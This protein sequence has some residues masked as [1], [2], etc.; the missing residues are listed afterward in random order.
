M[1]PGPARGTSATTTLTVTTD[2]S[3]AGLSTAT[4]AGLPPVFGTLA[5]AQAAAA[6]ARDLLAEHLEDGEVAVPGRLEL[7]HRTPV[8]VGTE[9]VLE[10]TVQMV[11]PTRVTCEILVRTSAGVAARSSYEQEVIPRADWLRRLSDV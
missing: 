5:M 2:M 7:I 4:P 6:V 10:A 8:P 3:D 1:R 11:E 9:V